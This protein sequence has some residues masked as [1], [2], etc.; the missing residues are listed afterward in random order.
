VAVPFVDAT[1]LLVARGMTGATGNWYCG[2][3][4]HCEMAF[5]L[6]ALRETDLFLDVGA[7]I[8]SYTIL[9]SGAA[10]ARS[11]AVEPVPATFA[12][13]R[14]NVALNELAGRVRCWQ[15]GL[16]DKA[17]SLTF[18]SGLDTVNHVLAA[19]EQAA[20]VEVPVTTL[21]EL[22]GGEVPTL[23]KIDVEGYERPV[24]A[25]AQRALADPRLLA[26]IMETNGSG[27]R[28]GVG[29]DELVSSMRE[30]GFGMYAYDPFARRL[31]VAERGSG[32]TIFV[33]DPEAV[34]VRVAGA[35]RFSLVNGSI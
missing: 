24:L 26:V 13:L 2:L 25:G 10:G 22:L 18:T 5:V 3:H 14:M 34:N 35:R 28:Y 6:H 16:A 30:H 9:A 17:G 27:V 19:G 15:G 12:H 32:N 23:I 4:E 31:N 11:I 8:G 21:D 29:D 20:G 7:N 1:R 33:R